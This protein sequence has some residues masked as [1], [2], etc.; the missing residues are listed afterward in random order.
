MKLSSAFRLGSISAFRLRSAVG[1]TSVV[2][3]CSVP[4]ITQNSQ[5]NGQPGSSTDASVA[6]PPSAKELKRKQKQ[7]EKELMG[8]WKKW[9]NED[10]L[11]IITDEEKQSF[12]QLKT[13]DERQQFVEAFW[14]RRDPTP[15]TEE[16]EYKEEHYR[17]IAYANDHYA[18][19]IPGWKTDRGR[20]YIKYGP[21][22][23]IDSHPSGGSYER[24][25]EEGGGETS[26][27]PFETWRY[28]YLDGIGT[29]IMIEFV[30]TTMSGEYHIATDPEEKDALL[31][32]PG[33]GLT[34]AE[35]MGT[36]DKTQRFTRTDGTHLG[37]GNSPLPESMNE[38]TVLERNAKLNAP[39]PIKFKDLQTVVDSNI[40]YNTLPMQ[41]RADYI[42]ITD[43]T[44]LTSIAIS[45]KNNDLQFK[46]KDTSAAATVNIYGRVTSLTR[47]PVNWFEDTVTAGPFPAESLDKVMG[48]KQLYSK[49]IPLAPGTYRLNVVAKD[50]VGNTVNNFE[51]ALNVPRYDEDTLGASSVILADEIER[52]PTNSIGS[53]PFVIRSS[54]VRPRVDVIFKQ[55][56]SLGIYAEL[57]NFGMDP[58]T[59]KP[60]GSV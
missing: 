6:K 9:L 21:P 16:N 59:K 52:V 40:K 34:L 37:T 45:F 18:S 24:P 44:V 35:Q 55:T 5:Q 38:F 23:E 8:P 15:D 57:Y 11:Y 13:D 43:S 4:A 28:R 25:I 31:M 22:D 12:K 60:E 33:A 20:M 58:K 10:V 56:E 7:L 14:E 46:T 32:V 36:A 42:R 19:G 47:R 1:V 50:T 54:K 48:G 53:G 30:D 2:L 26:T 41:V 51:M 3:L 49:T 27:Y 29:N 17:R 39:P